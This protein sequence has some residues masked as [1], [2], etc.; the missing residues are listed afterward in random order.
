METHFFQLYC[1]NHPKVVIVINLIVNKAGFCRYYEHH[2]EDGNNQVILH[3]VADITFF[4]VM[5]WEGSQ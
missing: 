3:R 5:L 1:G 4:E 2:E